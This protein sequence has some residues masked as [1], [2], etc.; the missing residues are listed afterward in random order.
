MS[1]LDSGGRAASA[2]TSQLS[3]PTMATS[4]YGDAAL[5]QRIGDA[6]GDLVVAAE[7]ARRGGAAA[8]K[9]RATA[10]RPQAS[11]QTPEQVEAWQ[12]RQAGGGERRALA[13]PAQAHGLEVLRPGDVGDAPAAERGQML[14][15]EY[16]AALVVGQQA[17]RAGIVGMGEDV[18]DRA[19]RGRAGRS[20]ARVSARRAVT[21]RPSTRLPSSWSRCWRSR[22]GSSVALHMKTAM[23]LVGE[24][25]LQRLDDRNGEAAEAVVGDDA[26]R[27][28][29]GRGAGC[30]RDRSA[31][32]R[33]RAATREHPVARL[34]P[35]AAAAV[36]RLGAVPIE[37]PA[38]RA[39]SWMVGGAARRLGC[40]A[41][42][43]GRPFL[44]RYFTAPL[45]K[46]AT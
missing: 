30:G 25:L 31:G 19:V 43:D 17:E 5:A 3:K 32:S 41:G 29:A 1:T 36:Q 7:D 16:R 35:Q 22:A 4:R 46:P 14:D 24:A 8:S 27:P 26:D 37:T 39:T 9:S 12:L 13:R 44:H 23:P 28:R 15:G 20:A 38:S 42:V 33:S 6:A 21:T 45:M 2:M 18:D 40:S 34:L 11:D 10:S